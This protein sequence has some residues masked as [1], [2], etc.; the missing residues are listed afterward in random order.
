MP[1]NDMQAGDVILGLMD[2]LVKNNK[3]TDG[4]I[5]YDVAWGS[6]SATLLG[7]DG[8]LTRV[9]WTN[10]ATEFKVQVGFRVSRV[11]SD[12]WA[13]GGIELVNGLIS[14]F[15]GG[16][17]IKAAAISAPTFTSNQT[18]ALKITLSAADATF[19]FK[20]QAARVLRIAAS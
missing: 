12:A 16:S 14:N 9:T 6:A 4:T 7:G 2:V 15:P 17:G 8:V 19:Y 20:P 18:V 13:T 10:S 5:T 1:A 3:G 11:G